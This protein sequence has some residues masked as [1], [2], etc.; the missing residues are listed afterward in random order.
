MNDLLR[1]FWEWIEMTPEQYANEKENIADDKSE[2]FF[3]KF[4]TLIK[5]AEYIVGKN[6]LIESEINDLLTILALDNESESVLE[7][8]E[9]HSSD[10]Q[11]ESIVSQGMSHIQ[12]NARWQLAELIYRRKVTDYRVK[13]TS[14]SEDEHPYVRKRALNCLN[15]LNEA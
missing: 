10:E 14:L 11:V 2:F 9:I 7:Y 1:Q 4:A 8:V 12:P 3:P 5:Y 13:L 6:S 15:Y